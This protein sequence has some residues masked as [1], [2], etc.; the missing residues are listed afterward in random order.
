MGFWGIAVDPQQR[1]AEERDE[2]RDLASH[3]EH[4]LARRLEGLTAHAHDQE[5]EADGGSHHDLCSIPNRRQISLPLTCGFRRETPE[6]TTTFCTM[7]LNP[8]IVKYDP[9]TVR[10]TLQE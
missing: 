6:E 5:P 8:D 4:V 10:V 2:L 7:S 1:D 9:K 3:L